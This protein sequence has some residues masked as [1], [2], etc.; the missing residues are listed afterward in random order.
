MFSDKDVVFRDLGKNIPRKGLL[1]FSV[2]MSRRLNMLTPKHAIV[3]YVSVSI[4]FAVFA[5]KF[6]KGITLFPEVTFGPDIEV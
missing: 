3:T 5:S 4:S 2:T 6:A 1:R